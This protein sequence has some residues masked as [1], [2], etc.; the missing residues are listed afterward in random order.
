MIDHLGISVSNFDASKT[1][2]D[3]AF[4]PLGASLLY[5]VPEQYTGGVKVGGY[6]RE[7]PVFWLH[8][9][10]PTGPGRHY[11]FT[12]RTR[13]EV[14]AFHKAAL[15]AGGKDNGAPGLRPHYHADYYGAFVF[16]PDGNNVE[17]VCHAPE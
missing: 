12:A 8:E 9:A 3:Q 17:A 6:G 11:A 1:F 10:S 5:V 13:A 2:Y 7:R 15:A 4:A 16:D 14:D